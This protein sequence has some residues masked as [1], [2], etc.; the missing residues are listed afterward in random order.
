MWSL[1][2]ERAFEGKQLVINL[3]TPQV[4]AI[5]MLGG[6]L[7][8]VD[9]QRVQREAVFPRR[10]CFSLVDANASLRRG[11]GETVAYPHSDL[12]VDVNRL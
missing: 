10:H 3:D 5:S 12:A 9:Q 1:D 4:D 6:K 8:Q 2:G 11:P 7:V